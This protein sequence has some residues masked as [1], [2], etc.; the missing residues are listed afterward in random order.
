MA[1]RIQRLH[2]P[3]V[4]SCRCRSTVARAVCSSSDYVAPA[5]RWVIVPGIHKHPASTS[6][7]LPHLPLKRTA[8][9][10]AS[11]PCV[12][13]QRRTK[14]HGLRNMPSSCLHG[15]RYDAH[16]GRCS[17]G[18]IAI[19][20][21]WREPPEGLFAVPRRQ[22]HGMQQLSTLLLKGLHP[23]RANHPISKDPSSLPPSHLVCPRLDSLVIS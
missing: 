16:H 12:H 22:S 23:F 14:C 5:L 15:L 9:S 2:D 17:L 4:R 10:S 1:A 6:L 13:H 3:R 8:E 21:R 20:R 7:L 18:V 19:L 11:S